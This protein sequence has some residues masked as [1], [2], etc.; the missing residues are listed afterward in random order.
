M[1]TLF[2]RS[3]CA[4]MLTISGC[5]GTAMDSGMRSDALPFWYVESSPHFSRFDLLKT[6][7]IERAADYAS[8]RLFPFATR[9]SYRATRDAT[10]RSFDQYGIDYILPLWTA[11][12]AESRR[13]FRLVALADLD[14]FSLFRH[15]S[16]S[17]ALDDGGS[18]DS[19][20]WSVLW[21]IGEGIVTLRSRTIIET[22]T[23]VAGEAVAVD[24]GR[25]LWGWLFQV[26]EYRSTTPE[27]STAQPSS[28]TLRLLRLINGY[29]L[30]FRD[31]AIEGVE[32]DF[33]LVGAFEDDRFAL[34]LFRW[35]TR[36]DPASVDVALRGEIL[37]GEL[38]RGS[39]PFSIASY[40]SVLGQ[41][42]LRVFPLFTLERRDGAGTLRLFHLVPISF[43]TESSGSR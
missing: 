8:F 33:R 6:L 40:E 24:F 7:H 1:R 42:T 11:E 4:L 15:E 20:E 41:S 26:G 39:F 27:A 28:H 16:A 34:S 25:M 9:N 30:L 21:W 31:H 19:E 12:V 3:G 23:P 2:A 13:G 18:R 17:E 14:Q 5:S 32:T 10:A 22:E 37:G 38:F 29:L 35:R 43:G 36:N